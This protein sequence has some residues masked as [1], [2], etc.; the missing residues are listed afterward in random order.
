MPYFSV[1]KTSP[2]FLSNPTR[3]D[4]SIDTKHHSTT[5]SWENEIGDIGTP[6]LRFELENIWQPWP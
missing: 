4:I 1:Q 6:D 5:H 3:Q 2:S